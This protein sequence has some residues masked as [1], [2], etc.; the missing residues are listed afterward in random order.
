MKRTA[1][2]LCLLML[3]PGTMTL[4]GPAA[5]SYRS[6][7]RNPIAIAGS[8]PEVPCVTTNA[9]GIILHGGSSAPF[10]AEGLPLGQIHLLRSSYGQMTLSGIPAAVEYGGRS[11]PLQRYGLGSLRTVA[12]RSVSAGAG[13]NTTTLVVSAGGN[14]LTVWDGDRNEL[15][16]VF[17]QSDTIV[18]SLAISLDGTFFLLGGANGIITQVDGRTGAP[19]R[20]F[21]GH[22][23]AVTSLALNDAGTRIFSGS[24][25]GTIRVWDLDACT[26]LATLGNNPG[27]VRAIAFSDVSD[28]LATSDGNTIKIWD[29]AALESGPVPTNPPTLS[30]HSA[31]VTS[32][33]FSADGTRVASG[34]EDGTA[35]VWNWSSRSQT[36]LIANGG[37]AVL[38]V[39]FS[40]D[41]TRVLLGDRNNRA[42]EFT[43]TGST[44]ALAR[45]L[46]GHTGE[47]NHVAYVGATGRVLSA[48]GRELVEGERQPGDARII[49]FEPG[50][51]TGAVL[52]G[53]QEGTAAVAFSGNGGFT[54][55]GGEDG[56][57][58]RFD[59][60]TGASGELDFLG[61]STSGAI[62]GLHYFQSGLDS[63][64]GRLLVAS[65]DKVSIWRASRSSA[66]T[67]APSVELTAHAGETEDLF[68]L[69][70][71]RE[72]VT[73]ARDGTAK[74]WSLPAGTDPT[75]SVVATFPHPIGTEVTAVALSSDGAEVVTVTRDGTA[76]WWGRGASTP[77][78]SLALPTTINDLA[79][80]DSADQPLLAAAGDDGAVYLI[81][82]GATPAVSATLRGHKQ[83]PVRALAYSSDGRYLLSGSTDATLVSW[84]VARQAQRSRF[85]RHTGAVTSLRF[86]QIDTRFVSGG[87]D[88][89]AFLWDSCL[90]SQGR[91]EEKLII[92]AGGGDY[93]TNPIRDETFSLAQRAYIVARTRGYSDDN[94]LYLTAYKDSPERQA[95]LD[96]KADGPATYEAVA[97]GI[98]EWSKDARRLFVMLLD[99]GD[100]VTLPG[101][102]I[103]WY[104]LLSETPGGAR[105][106]ISATDFDD[107]LDSAQ[108]G[109]DPLPEV[110]LYADMCY[111]GGFV[112]KASS[113]PS[114]SVLRTVLA[115]TGEDRLAVFG[116]GPGAPLSF[117]SF[118][119]SRAHLG[120][121][122]VD[123]FNSARSTMIALRLPAAKP[124]IPELDANGDGIYAPGIDNPLVADRK[125]VLGNRLAFGLIPPT[126]TNFSG[127][128]TIAQPVDVPVEVI[129]EGEVQ[130]AEMFVVYAEGN[131]D[132]QTDPITNF[133]SLP[134]TRAGNTTRWRG[135][136]PAATFRDGSN[137]P[138]PGYYTVLYSIT[139]SD[140]LESSVALF[141]DPKLTTIGVGITVGVTGWN[142]R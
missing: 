90:E 85:R 128:V 82:Q 9:G 67:P 21:R 131:Y 13:L 115:S 7:Y 98:S 97:D 76:R 47:V 80:I 134:L 118:F 18:R 121:S 23:G 81:S 22:A 107:L 89:Q 73:G 66:Q 99:H 59:T 71:R 38:G 135:T 31:L 2:P 26:S 3:L 19:M 29:V 119:L 5:V 87:S 142:L 91:I 113:T 101:G 51:T 79:L 105:E 117:T 139:R 129:L 100:R 122:L 86:A 30:G 41:G 50:S 103:E 61:R 4:A 35:R 75:P 141:A 34:S 74:L 93:P 96:G 123:S 25:D 84:D 136:V 78:K 37:V 70:A 8:V 124:Q 138:R 16:R 106:R 11:A 120:N 28:R 40:P 110:I 69:D 126:I 104:F 43:L 95:E 109:L 56:R 53:H 88:G 45:D 68:F 63:D 15:V 130:G 140:T 17:D 111:A 72:F 77:S 36:N 48:S 102:G 55:T 114:A 108:D 54:F 10:P 116:G 49:V 127:N 137:A 58:R 32:L 42:R 57:L 65:G 133:T 1:F 14:G 125:F 60:A 94:I 33:A 112:K 6:D 62:T 92:V 39:A 44:A 52:E 12:V 46:S 132:S 64:T 24:D 20:T 83:S 27:G